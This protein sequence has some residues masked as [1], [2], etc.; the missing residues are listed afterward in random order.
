M[1]RE[2]SPLL[3]SLLLLLLFP[4]LCFVIG[5]A[6]DVCVGA[7]AGRWGTHAEVKARTILFEVFFLS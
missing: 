7:A 3:P 4:L 2:L 1:D 6:V 5:G